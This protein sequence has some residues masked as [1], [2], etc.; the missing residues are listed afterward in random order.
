M[1][2]VLHVEQQTA[3]RRRFVDTASAVAEWQVLHREADRIFPELRTVWS[4]VFADVSAGIDPEALETALESGSLL[5]VESML[6]PVW[7][8]LGETQA[9]TV[10]PLLLSDT[11]QRAAAAVLPTVQADLGVH[12]GGVNPAAVQWVEQYAGEQIQAIGETTLQA[13]RQLLRQ[14]FTE[15]RSV[16]QLLGD[17]QTQLGLTPRQAQAV[18]A[19]GQRLAAEGVP[20][21]QAA[22]QEAQYARRLLRQRV[23]TVARTEAMAAANAGQESLWRQAVQHGLLDPER[24]RRHWLVTPDD[25]LCP[26]C[27]EIPD[28][29][30]EGVALDEPFQTP[31]GAVQRPPAHPNCRCA[32]DGKVVP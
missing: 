11:V 6:T 15:G 28:M 13:V 23:E 1:P 19:F 17:L 27:Q 21:G 2:L 7:H 25:R 12:L 30:P 18:E 22:W 29:N 8:Q 24:F 4:T 3:P 16:T 31:V 32:V 10:L 9:R 26:V 20:P 5:E 14:A